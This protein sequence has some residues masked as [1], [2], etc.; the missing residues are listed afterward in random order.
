MGRSKLATSSFRWL[1]SFDHGVARPDAD[2]VRLE[3]VNDLRA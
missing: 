2:L 3:V 1:S